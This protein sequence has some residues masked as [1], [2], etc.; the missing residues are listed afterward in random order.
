MNF[1]RFLFWW[2]CGGVATPEAPSSDVLL[3][4]I[5]DRILL[6]TGDGILLE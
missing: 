3:M 4:E 2:A 5:G 1:L 6:E